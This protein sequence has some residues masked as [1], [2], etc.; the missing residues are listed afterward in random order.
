MRCFLWKVRAT[1]WY[2]K[3]LKYY[4]LPFCWG[5]AGATLDNIGYDTED[6]PED[7]VREELTYWGD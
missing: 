1:Y 2:I 6:S 3:L 7:C 5:M 4:N